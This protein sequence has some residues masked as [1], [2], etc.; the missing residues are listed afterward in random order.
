MHSPIPPSPSPTLRQLTAMLWK[1]LGKGRVL[2][3]ASVIL[4]LGETVVMLLV[5]LLMEM[6]FNRLELGQLPYIYNLMLISTVIV[7]VLLGLTILGFYYKQKSMSALQRDVSLELADEAQRLPLQ[8]ATASHSADLAQRIWADGDKS[9]WIL[10]T[11]FHGIGSQA[12]MLVLAAIYM[13]WL[14]WEIALGLFV[15][16]PLG[17]LG[18]HLLRRKLGVIGLAVADQEAA[19]R[20]CQQDAL[21]GME[22][23]RAFGAE[24]WM[25]DRFVVERHK[26]NGLYM[27]RM[28]WNELVN[29]LTVSLSLLITWGSVLAVAWLAVQGKLQ[30]GA[31]MAF[32]VLVWRIYNPLVNIGRM[33]GEVQQNLGQTARISALWRAKK[34]PNNFSPTLNH[35][36][37]SLSGIEQQHSI[38]WSNVSFGYDEHAGIQNDQANDVNASKSEA[39]RLL[40]QQFSLELRPGSFTAIVGPSGSGK[41]TAAKLGAGLLLP[42]EGEVS[43]CGSNPNYNAEYARQFVAYVPQSPYL[44]AG[45]IRDNLLFGKPDASEAELVDAAKA[46]AAH[47]FIEALPHGYDTPLKEHGSSLS[48]GQKQRLAI[49]RAMLS[50]RPIWIFDE[51]TSALDTDTERFV[52]E[53]VRERTLMHGST[54]LVIA[55]RLTTVQDADAII[56][57][58]N[59]LIAEQGT[60][61]LLLQRP[62][63]L[64]RKLWNKN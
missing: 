41:S 13:L 6:Y 34:E 54:L 64:Y 61:E 36:A 4:S 24:G 9:S 32:F 31:L 22:T 39:N 45:T 3:G 43:I 35:A 59:G 14:Q 44:F 26:L 50:G 18:S 46:A 20:Q 57:M 30:I 40:L 2:F 58:E 60:H 19:V 28:W 11:L 1:K 63:G 48:G 10:S 37:D 55:H 23:L 17:I 62:E 51:A 5:P 8:K 12:I 33:W 49:A 25:M 52:M 15:L 53:S 56:V 7:I 38:R 21:Q 16:M 47:A 27:Q 29:G 42:D